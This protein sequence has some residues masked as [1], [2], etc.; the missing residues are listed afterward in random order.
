MAK[1]V[2]TSRS[3]LATRQTIEAIKTALPDAKILWTGFR[4]VIAIDAEGDPLDLARELSIECF[5]D[6]GRAV[7]VLA[8]IQSTT[9]EI[10]KA[11]TEV[12][13]EHIHRGEKFCFRLHKRGSHRLER[14]TPELEYE[15]GRAIWEVLNRKY[16]ELP[17]VDLK[18]PDVK[19]IAEVL[20]PKT[21]IGILRREW[22]LP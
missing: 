6:I 14:P 21:C 2:I 17:R 15:I 22:I 12:G 8:E 20:G 10:K 9:E 19:V 13:A 16:G 11:A 4:G 18:S 5:A 1:L 3:L 7:P